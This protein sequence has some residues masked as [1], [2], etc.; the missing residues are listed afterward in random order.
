MKNNEYRILFTSVGRRVE[1]VQAFRKA[2]RNENIKLR[3][4]AADMSENA[5]ALYYCDEA[6]K[7]CRITD[8]NYIPSLV[9][10]CKNENIDLLIPTIDTD[11][12]KL[13]QSK[14]Q[15]EN[16]G[17]KVLI[18]DV[19]MIQICRDK[20][21]TGDFF[22]SCGLHAPKV[23]DDYTKYDM[24]Y[25][26]FIKPKDGSSSIN[27]YKVKDAQE[28]KELAAKVNDYVVQ[29]FID[30][31][32]Y[33]VDIFCDFDRNPIFI[34]PRERVAVRGGEVLQTK[35][36]SDESILSECKLLIEKFRPYGPITV[37]LIKDNKT[38]INYY[39]EI[40]PR[41]GGGAPLSIKAGA[42]S[43]KVLLQLLQ[44]KNVDSD[45]LAAKAGKSYSRF[46]Q[47]IAITDKRNS[48]VNIT[49]LL[50]VE[51]LVEKKT[52]VIFDLDDTL[53]NECDYV[54]SGYKSVAKYLCD[55]NVLKLTME[56]IVEFLYEAFENKKPAFDLFFEKYNML[57]TDIKNECIS[58]YRNHKPAIYLSQD[59][60]ELLRRLRM[61]GKK[62]GIITD[63]RANGQR[64]KLEAL[65]LLP[66]ID[67]YIITDELAGNA[68]VTKFRKPNPL[69]FQIMQERLGEEFDNMVY[70]GDNISKDFQAPINLGMMAVWYQNEKGLYK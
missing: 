2:A 5:P 38:G 4:Y 10:I 23:F 44:G 14:E 65:G 42:D 62:I 69:A 9:A 57:E 22:E 3:I 33:T 28:L 35:I 66:L 16:I 17:T 32:E 26:C 61:Q 54:R 8:E 40:N 58:I 59:N 6:I 47:S 52:A 45:I 20:R 51:E 18:S 50:E 48:I 15:F 56:E 7:I 37:Q 67:E 68:D 34:T 49:N 63:G 25:P 41:Y 39:I 46:D 24:E 21:F 27:A 30:G 13:S 31:T 36:V 55:K 60:L 64:N 29:P 43:P 12:L 53:Y 70:I 1:L 19:Q 11:L